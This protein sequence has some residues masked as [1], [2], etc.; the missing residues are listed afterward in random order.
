[1]SG[2]RRAEARAVCKN[3]IPG[4]TGRT[5]P[6]KNLLRYLSLSLLLAAGRLSAQGNPDWHLEFPGVKIAG[7]LYY[8]GTADLAV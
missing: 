5:Y 6:M 3:G 2:L 4:L 7:N 8:V 1:M